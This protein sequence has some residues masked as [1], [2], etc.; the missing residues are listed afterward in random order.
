MN[1]LEN[2]YPDLFLNVEDK[3]CISLYQPTHR[4]YP[5]RDQDNIRYKNLVKQIEQSLKEAYS[6]DDIKAFIRPFHALQDDYEFWNHMDHGLAILANKNFF[7]V[8]KL[9]R[10]VP[11][12]AI[13]A[14]GFHI[15]PLIRIMQSADR[16]Q[17]LGL[18]RK[19]IT[20]YEGN[21][22]EL[23]EVVLHEEVPKTIEDALGS[24]L[25]EPRLTV[26][27]YGTGAGGTPMHHGHGGRKDEVDL[28]AEKFFRRVDEA[29]TKYHSRISK[30]P[31]ILAALPEHH[32]LYHKVSE[33]EYLLKKDIQV[34]P[35][36][37]TVDELKN[38]AWDV[39]Q[40]HY[41]SRLESLISRYQAMSTDC[42]GSDQM[43]EVAIAAVS[44]RVETLLID[45]DKR[46]PG[47]IDPETGK[48][49]KKDGINPA[50]DDLLDELGEF[51]LKSR[52]EVVVVPSDKMPSD[53]GLAAIYRY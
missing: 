22:D 20:L 4:T 6:E 49:I 27:D 9:P 52:G 26:S 29:I 51:V 25:T 16:F 28:D 13:V 45:A 21:R 30:I 32:H 17:I 37:L 43:S 46:I 48:T 42:R 14:D 10:N 8:Y 34:N 19:H 53:T 41:L 33:N 7:K 3:P 39:M 5:D 50:V 1:S 44:G 11:E 38:R 31:L 36:E 12:I 18:T 47:Q 24:E 2:D 35:D 40:E 15:K 23:S